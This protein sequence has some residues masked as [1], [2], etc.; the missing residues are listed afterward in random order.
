MIDHQVHRHQRLDDLRVFAQAR[1]H[2]AHRGQVHQQRHT[3]KILQHN[4][5]DRKRNLLRALRIRLPSGEL[6]DVLLRHFLAVAIA[7]YRLQN[8]ADTNRQAR[9]IPQAGLSQ[10]R[11]RVKFSLLTVA[12][13]KR[14]QCVERIVTH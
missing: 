9:E 14:L 12:K 3:G 13:V 10:R 4:P 8:Q 6:A 11:Q 7:K 2:R 5:G 1:R